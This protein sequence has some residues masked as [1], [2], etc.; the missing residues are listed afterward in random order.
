MT[1]ATKCIRSSL[2]P[3]T[4]V[5]Q[6]QI[7]EAWPEQFQVV[8]QY[9]DVEGGQVQAKAFVAETFG[10]AVLAA[11]CAA[12]RRPGTSWMIMAGDVCLRAGETP[13]VVTVMP[14]VPR[15]AEMARRSYAMRDVEVM[16]SEC[17]TNVSEM[18]RV[19]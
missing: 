5:L 4:V 16:L 6:R 2:R 7:A 17:V 3:S 12:R 10:D 8:L 1:A 18:A 19:R 9:R 11:Y 14:P 15:T 13:A